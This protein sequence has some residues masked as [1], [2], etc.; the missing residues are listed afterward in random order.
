MVTDAFIFV[1]HF[2]VSLSSRACRVSNQVADGQFDQIVQ[3][4]EEVVADPLGPLPTTPE[5]FCYLLVLVDRASHWIEA[6]A[7]RGN[8]A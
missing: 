5:G 7:M 3:P 4:S 6:F 8:S 2:Y 1:G